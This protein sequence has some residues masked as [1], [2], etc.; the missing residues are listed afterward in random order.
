MIVN[1]GWILIKHIW[2]NKLKINENN[3]LK[4]I[5]DIK[6]KYMKISEI[7]YKKKYFSKI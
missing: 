6:I 7:N 3:C 4:G 1:K 2:L 5:D